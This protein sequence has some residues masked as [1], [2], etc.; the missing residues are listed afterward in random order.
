MLQTS[1][2][3]WRELSRLSDE[4]F[5]AKLTVIENKSVCFLMKHQQ[6]LGYNIQGL[7]FSAPL[8]SESK[9]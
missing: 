1:I 2:L 8:C 4:K 3:L 7:R 9:I 6:I 5:W